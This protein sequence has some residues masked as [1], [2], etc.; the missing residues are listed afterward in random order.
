MD[1]KLTLSAYEGEKPYIFVS[2]AHK[3]A[4][5]VLPAIALLQ[6]AGYRIWFDQG[7]EAGSEWP[8]YIED[9]LVNSSAVLI[10]MSEYVVESVNCRNE[11][12]LAHSLKK[13]MLVI[14]LEPTQ[15]R[16]GLALQLGTVQSIA[17]HELS[18]DEEFL[19]EVYAVGALDRCAESLN[20]PTAE[21]QK[22]VENRYLSRKKKKRIITVAA[23]ALA[24]LIIGAVLLFTGLDP[25]KNFDYRTASDGI[26][27]T[28][29]KVENPTSLKIPD[30]IDGRP[31]V[32]ID[33]NALR[34]YTTLET[35]TFGAHVRE[36][37]EGAFEG[38]TAL[39]AV[40]LG[41]R[42]EV[43]YD[44]AFLGCT[45][46][47]YLRVDGDA[48][49]EYNAFFDCPIETAI[50]PGAL[51][52]LFVEHEFDDNDTLVSMTVTRGEITESAGQLNALKTLI[53]SDAVT[54]VIPYEG[55]CGAQALE[56]VVIGDGIGGIEEH[57]FSSC[58]ALRSVTLGKSIAYIGDYAFAY[59]EALSEISLPDTVESLG[60]DAFYNCSSLESIHLSAALKSIGDDC[61]SGCTALAEIL[62]PEGL[63]SIGNGAFRGCKALSA[64]VIPDSVTMLGQGA[65]IDCEGLKTADIGDGVREIGPSTFFCCFMLQEV[66]FGKNLETIREKAFS[67]CHALKELSFPASLDAVASEAFSHCVA[68][69]GVLFQPGTAEIL[70]NAFE[71]CTALATIWIPSTLTTIRA[72][73]FKGCQTPTLYTPLPSAPQYWDSSVARDCNIVFAHTGIWPQS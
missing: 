57:A 66:T 52:S 48:V 61:F 72:N 56:S 54:G 69:T 21:R 65:F 33:A 7:I 46:L 23:V 29:V 35:V 36:I 62:L 67:G 1:E 43:I 55:F 24:V 18:S 49:A 13:D 20:K 5:E 47:S 40:T 22:Q 9:H 31:V 68:L 6:K 12:N 14:N 38:C 42:V 64:I 45:A 2:Y 59:C 60:A 51:V 19:S 11:I 34:G 63:E 16:R 39:T 17:K 26:H 50:V 27:I 28:G 73:A 44:H 30:K 41:E 53:I 37:G 15:L 71:G 58:T 4:D 70:S 8:E 3:N 25:A 10:F 32:G